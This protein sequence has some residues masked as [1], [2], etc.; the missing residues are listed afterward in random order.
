ME[1]MRKLGVIIGRVIAE[2]QIP[3]SDVKVGIIKGTASYPD[4]IALTDENGEYD[5]EYIS[6]GTFTVSANKE[7]YTTQTK[8]IKVRADEEVRLDFVLSRKS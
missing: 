7:E 6:T 4:L 3:I 8:T 1:D 2:K 5:L